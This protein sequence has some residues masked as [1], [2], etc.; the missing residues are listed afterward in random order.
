MK[1]HRVGFLYWA[2]FLSLCLHLSLAPLA[3]DLKF[4]EADKPVPTITLDTP[5]PKVTAPP[6]PVPTPKPRL[7]P[8]PRVQSKPAAV[9]HPVHL[10]NRKS[11]GKREIAVTPRATS[12]PDIAPGLGNG[13]NPGGDGDVTAS[14]GPTAT[15]KPVCSAPLVDASTIEKY[16]PEM[17]AAARDAGLT[18]TSQVKVDLSATGTVLDATIATSSGS[19]ILDA[20]AIQAAKRT[21]YAPKVL[22]CQR[23][24]G[25]YLFR[26]EF[27]NN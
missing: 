10:Q 14:P 20:A 19:T 27:D 12:G 5:H 13:G 9:A 1:R 2:L 6:T 11:D 22:D 25:S 7:T 3:Q 21:T 8:Q 15:P 24:P 18:G 17:P 23:V 4:T 16:T 26:V